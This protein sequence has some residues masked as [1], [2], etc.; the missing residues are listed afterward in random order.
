MLSSIG[1]DS[2]ER[3]NSEQRTN[4]RVTAHGN[5]RISIANYLTMAK[6]LVALLAI[7]S[8][9]AS[10]FVSKTRTL[11][12]TTS[13]PT[14]H[15]RAL[16]PRRTAIH[17]STPNDNSNNNNENDLSLG[18]KFGGFTVKQRL[19]EEV[20]SP[21]RKV[22]LAFFGFFSASASIA[23]YFSALAALKANMGGF[24]DSVPLDEALQTCA[25]NAAGALGFG[26]LALRE[27]KA[28]QANLERIAKGGL[29]ARLG[30]QSAANI[31]SSSSSRRSLGDYRRA[32]RVIIAAGGSEY[33][34]KLAL[35][36][37]SDQLSDVNTLPSALAGVD[38]VVVPVLLDKEC[39]VIDVKSAWKNVIPGP[40]DR[41]YDSARADEIVA[42]PVGFSNWNDYLQS[43]VETAKKQGFDVL[44][45]GITITVKKNGRV[46]RR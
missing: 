15:G 31:A 29:L 44:V 12:I 18:E 32:S 23:L 7:L 2:E 8:P 46:L 21:F 19:R 26:A 9:T 5:K 30:V 34:N 42:F 36:L 45:K 14:T 41:N 22:R 39:K 6:L 24:A 13:S 1:A 38:I 16:L 40:N 3:K 11:A 25:I 37:C 43:D 10:A 28:G 35:S 27:M 4:H 17:F 20:E 33:I